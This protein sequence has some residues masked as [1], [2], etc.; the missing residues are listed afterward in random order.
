MASRILD[1]YGAPTAGFNRSHRRPLRGQPLNSPWIDP[2]HTADVILPADKTMIAFFG[3][4][5]CSR[6]IAA[7]YNSNIQELRQEL[8]HFFES[9]NKNDF[10]LQKVIRMLQ[11]IPAHHIQNNTIQ[12]GIPWWVDYLLNI[13]ESTRALHSWLIAVKYSLDEVS[14]E[15][16]VTKE[17]VLDVIRKKMN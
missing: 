9:S 12:W 14:V 16:R 15:W 10:S 11:L 4:E 3:D 8:L 17:Q 1:I 5:N 2:N 13:P 7:Y 6:I